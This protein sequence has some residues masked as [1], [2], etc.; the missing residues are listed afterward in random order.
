MSRIRVLIADD[1]AMIRDGLRLLVDSQP[2]MECIGEAG[3][4]RVAV[5]RARELLP[6]VVLMDVSMP[7]MNGLKATEK[8]KQVCPQVKV[9]MLTRHTDDGYLQELIRAGAS[10]YVLKQ[11]SSAEMLN[12]VR[13]IAAGN[14][15][16]DPTLTGRVM[17]GYVGRQR[18]FQDGSLPG[19]E[20]SER[21]ADVLRM[22]AWGHG[23]KEIAARLSISVKTVDVHKANALKKLGLKGRVDIVR[24]ALLQGWLKET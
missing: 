8:I 5:E 15:Y 18:T 22:I 2:D 12:A 20:L 24:F 10:G 23:N 14:S 11:S 21:E 7:Q 19:K 9:L 16:L 17:D 1:H 6:D 13:A 4:G 3:D